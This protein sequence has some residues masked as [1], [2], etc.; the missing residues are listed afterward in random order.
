MLRRL[1]LRT[2][3]VV[4]ASLSGASALVVGSGLAS[5]SSPIRIFASGDSCEGILEVAARR[6]YVTPAQ[7][8]A[9]NALVRR[10]IDDVVATTADGHP[11]SWSALSDGHPALLVFIKNGCPCSVE[12]EPYFHRLYE[13]YRGAVRFFGVIDGD[14]ATAR[15]YAT[16]NSVP[17]PVMADPDERVIDRFGAK[18]GGYA[19]LLDSEG[20]IAGFWPGF[21]EEAMSELGRRMSRLVGVGERPIETAGLPKNLTSGCP[22]DV[23]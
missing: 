4:L 15:R 20:V 18:N 8:Q 21:S 11:M 17:Y 6:H 5:S 10:T 9:S 1:R 14:A 23:R 16:T 3:L 7:L 12:L 2:T 13:A 22:F 19:A